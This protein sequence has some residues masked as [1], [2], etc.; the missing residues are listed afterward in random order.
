MGRERAGLTSTLSPKSKGASTQSRI[1]VGAGPG[2]STFLLEPGRVSSGLPNATQQVE[3]GHRCKGAPPPPR[4]RTTHMRQVLSRVCPVPL[5]PHLQAALSPLSFQSPGEPWIMSPSPL[6]VPQDPSSTQEPQPPG[7]CQ[8]PSEVP[9]IAG[10][11]STAYREPNVP[12]AC[13]TM[14]MLLW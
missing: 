13:A 1:L 11:P 4:T 5:P 10:Q 8:I 6:S 3:S 7:S 12:H 9:C 14:L 2:Q